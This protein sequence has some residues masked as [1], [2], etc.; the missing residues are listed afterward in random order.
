MCE[1]I[2]RFDSSPFATRE[3]LPFEEFCHPLAPWHPLFERHDGV[4]TCNLLYSNLKGLGRRFEAKQHLVVDV[5][6]GEKTNGLPFF[7]RS[8]GGSLK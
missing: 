4:V 7:A 3:V 2:D 6:F 8:V 5:R 1:K